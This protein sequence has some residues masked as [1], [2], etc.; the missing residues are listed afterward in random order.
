MKF[1]RVVEDSFKRRENTLLSANSPRPKWPASKGQKARG[2]AA[3]RRRKGVSRTKKGLARFSLSLRL[4]FVRAYTSPRNSLSL[5]REIRNKSFFVDSIDSPLRS[6]SSSR[7][8][9][10]VSPFL[11]LFRTFRRKRRKVA[12]NSFRILV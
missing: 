3:T 2:G 10:R 12:C 1:P 9:L 7:S 6:S 8:F 4:V 5:S 11:V